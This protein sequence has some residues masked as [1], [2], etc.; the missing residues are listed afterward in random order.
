MLSSSKINY[1]YFFIWVGPAHM[2]LLS[3][4]GGTRPQVFFRKIQLGCMSRAS[5]N[6]AQVLK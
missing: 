3:L 5:G 6:K 1:F 4:M 2:Y